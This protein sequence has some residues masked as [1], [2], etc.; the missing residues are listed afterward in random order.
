MSDDSVVR[1][2]PEAAVTLRPARAGRVGGGFWAARQRV[3]RDVTIPLGGTRIRESGAF[4]NL[5]RA[6]RGSAGGHQGKV[7]ADSDVYKWLEAL[8]WERG[9]ADNGVLAKAYEEAAGLVAAAQAPDGYLHTHTQLTGRERYS[10][11]ASSHELYCAGH[12]MQAA[13]AG[14]R[15]VGDDTL[16]RVA[17]RLAD[18]LVKDL[19]ADTLDGHPEIETA[20]AELYRETGTRPYLD[21]AA[22]MVTTRGGE[23]LPLKGHHGPGIRQD[24][25][26]LRRA[27]TVEGHAVRAVYLAAGAT[28]VAVETA[29]EDLLAALARQ[30]RDMVATKTYLTGGL[31]SV[32]YGEQF[33]GPHELTPETAYCETCA[34]VG[35]V[36]WAWRML[37]A[38][39]EAD[40]ADL[41]ERTLYNAVLPG[42][43]L[44]GDR[45][46]YV[47]ALRV[48]AGANPDD[49]R[50][51]ARGR[52]DWYGTACCPPNVMRL[53]SSLGHYL[54][55]EDEEGVQVHLYASGEIRA[56][57]A[58]LEVRTDYPWDGRVEIVV[59]ETPDRP[60]TLALRIPAW[61]DGAG[62]DGQPARAG[63]YHR[64]RRTWRP[65]DRITLDL[66]VRPR[67]TA[68][69]PRLD[70]ARGQVAV[71][72]GPLVYCLEQPDHPG[73]IVDDLC[74]A[75][76]PA[77]RDGSPVAGLPAEVV[78]VLA[79]GRVHAHREDDAG[80]PYRSAD[81]PR[82]PEHTGPVD[83]TFVPYYAWANRGAGPMTIWA[84]MH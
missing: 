18:H 43:S 12:L 50:A 27:T 4:A 83:L 45:F 29:D 79:R 39:G 30:W 68:A 57:G 15:A 46:F 49:R 78:P 63:G 23:T 26:P 81:G 41:M 60:W 67:L 77:L 42:L 11:L 1:P 24:R 7:F 59:R 38:T 65:G 32:W 33:G 73:A 54:A 9:R 48:R 52:Q 82:E 2:R 84:P 64:V 20:L 25:V 72:R 21:L 16:L 56:R 8:A 70:V 13:V 74:V 22:R 19:P 28:D 36:Q 69:V 53:F 31:G 10:D 34:A 5:E 66:A 61:A 58:L 62:V 14:S 3:N 37:L 40:F 17:T 55:S 71:E 51:A 44:G 47:N 35:S 80:F 75:A 76:D 6:A